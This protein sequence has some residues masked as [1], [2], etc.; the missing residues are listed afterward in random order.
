MFLPCIV[1]FITNSVRNNKFTVLCIIHF[2]NNWFSQDS[3]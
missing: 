3:V 2:I 1:N